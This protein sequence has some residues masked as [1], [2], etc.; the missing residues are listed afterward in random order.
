M[1]YIKVQSYDICVILSTIPFPS[2]VT[3]V[4]RVPIKLFDNEKTWG[5]FGKS[6]SR[7]CSKASYCSPGR[8]EVGFREHVRAVSWTSAEGLLSQTD[9]KGDG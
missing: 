9:Q 6:P 2:S 7:K 3:N 5:T 8:T 4:G 1:Y